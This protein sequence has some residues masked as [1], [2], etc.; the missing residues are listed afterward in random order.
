M[1]MSITDAQNPAAVANSL[2]FEI[3][4]EETGGNLD[5]S[6]A[7]DFA[8]IVDIILEGAVESM[9]DSISSAVDSILE[10]AIVVYDYSANQLSSVVESIDEVYENSGVETPDNI[11]EMVSSEEVIDEMV[12]QGVITEAEAKEIESAVETA[13]ETLTPSDET[14]PESEYAL[15]DSCSSRFSDFYSDR[16]IGTQ[17][18]AALSAAQGGYL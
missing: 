13:A 4:N 1:R 3:Y 2:A 5:A 14:I 16:E 10:V 11:A 15:Y 18:G 17:A 8:Q 7:E 9:D 6:N 12:D